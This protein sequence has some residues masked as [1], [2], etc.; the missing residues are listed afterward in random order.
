M[1]DIEHLLCINR[2]GTLK[3]SVGTEFLTP[4]RRRKSYLSHS[5][6][7]HLYNFAASLNARYQDNIDDLADYDID[8]N[9]ESLS[10]EYKLSNIMQAKAFTE[11]LEH[12]NCF[13]TDRLVDYD[14]LENF[15]ADQ[16][17]IIGPLEHDRWNNEKLSMG[18]S[19]GCDYEKYSEKKMVRERFRQHKLINTDYDSLP[20]EEQDKDTEPMSR[21]LRLIARYDGLRVYHY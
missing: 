21:M 16:M 4:S 15:T 7:L 10:L 5:S 3:I 17:D 19:S 14:Q 20:K 8:R 2:P 13:Y 11:Y 18:W 9:F 6:Y 12:V 1:A